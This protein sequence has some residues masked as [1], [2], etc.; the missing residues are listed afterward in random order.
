MSSR[1]KAETT[2]GLLVWSPVPMPGMGL[3]LLSFP[4][5]DATAGLEISVDQ[6]RATSRLDLLDTRA[7]PFGDSGTAIHGVHQQLCGHGQLPRSRILGLAESRLRGRFAPAICSTA[8][9]AD[10]EATI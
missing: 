5:C 8:P 1:W 10:G 4:P 2:T 9:L 3:Y 7:S 6:R